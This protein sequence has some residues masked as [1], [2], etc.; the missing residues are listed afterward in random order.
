[1]AFEN[2]TNKLLCIALFLV[3]AAL[4]LASH[5]SSRPID[6]ELSMV[7]RHEHWIARHG[8]VYKD[9]AEKAM[10]FKVFRDNVKRI[11]S[12]NKKLNKSYTIGENK[13]TDLTDEEFR[14]THTGY[15]KFP[16]TTNLSTSFQPTTT[17]TPNGNITFS[18]DND[19]VDWRQQ[20]A[21]TDVKNQGTC[22]KLWLILNFCVTFTR[23][24]WKRYV[25]LFVT[26]DQLICSFQIVY[27]FDNPNINI[28]T[29]AKHFNNY[30][31]EYV[32]IIPIA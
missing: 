27:R 4:F 17:A 11:E 23:S 24:I 6:Q 31:I 20:G 28:F 13:F 26:L 22:G 32:L 8:R 12:F 1:M 15:R 5:A 9:E 19:S 7:E 18:S 3:S 30:N 14:F 16:S 25:F 2:Q 10:R 29:I 21:V